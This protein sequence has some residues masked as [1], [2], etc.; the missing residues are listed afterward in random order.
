MKWRNK[1]GHN[2][3]SMI[4]SKTLSSW[5][6]NGVPH[7][8][9]CCGEALASID[10]VMLQHRVGVEALFEFIW[11][12]ATDLWQMK[13]KKDSQIIDIV[14]GGYCVKFIHM[15]FSLLKFLKIYTHDSMCLPTMVKMYTH[16][17]VFV[18]EKVPLKMA[19]PR[20]HILVKLPPPPP[21]ETW[22]DC[23]DIEGIS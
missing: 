12:M 5:N 10:Q 13:G 11:Q 14:P 8:C 2:S 23:S 15:I 1:W 16:N 21:E 19:R 18:D 17:S 22:H 6:T 20:Y 4:A 7:L 9:S 3:V